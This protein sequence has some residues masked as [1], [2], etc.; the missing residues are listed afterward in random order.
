MCIRDRSSFHR[1]QREEEDHSHF[2]HW[3]HEEVDSYVPDEFSQEEYLREPPVFLDDYSIPSPTVSEVL[4]T[5]I[6]H[7]AFVRDGRGDPG[8]Q[9]SAPSVQEFSNH[10]YE[11]LL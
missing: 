8:G 5:Q 7:K 1:G 2:H 10:Y 4:R 6:Y 3:H 11:H 9:P